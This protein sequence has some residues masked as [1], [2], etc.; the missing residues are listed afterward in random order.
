MESRRRK[1]LA[2]GILLGGLVVAWFFRPSA[3]VAWVAPR[4]AGG[5]LILRKQGP[6][7]GEAAK[8]F[9]SLPLLPS[10]SDADSSGSAP[11][12]PKAGGGIRSD[13]L[14]ALASR[15][16]FPQADASFGGTVRPGARGAPPCR[17]RIVDGDTLKN[18]AE[19]Y[20]GSPALAIEIYEANRSVLSD[21]QLLPI[22]VEIV[23][24][25]RPTPQAVRM[26]QL[27]AGRLLPVEEAVFDR[28]APASARTSPEL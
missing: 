12:C 13:P 28:T 25:L 7:P 14:P 16:P 9:S 5:K 2:L 17:H 26:E 11:S 27:Q 19:R 1:L 21:P 3:S 24:P 10:P 18:L 22:G 23:I 8:S 15:F 20:L 4:W 6:I